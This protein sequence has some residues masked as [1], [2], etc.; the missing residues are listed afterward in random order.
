MKILCIGD[1]HGRNYWKNWVEQHKDADLIIFLGD[2]VDSIFGVSNVEILHN[3]KEIIYFRKTHDNVVTLLGNHDI[4]YL[5]DMARSAYHYCSG[6]RAEAYWDLHILF[7][8]NRHLF[9]AAYKIQNYLFTHAGISN[10][11]FDSY[12]QPDENIDKLLNIEFLRYNRCMFDIGFARLG[13]NPVGGPFWA[14]KT[15]TMVDP[16]TGY[17]QIVGHTRFSE[18]TTVKK[19]DNTS[20]TFVD[21]INEPYIL[22]I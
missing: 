10:Q 20:I 22:N 5:Y 3:L 18:V 2:Y 16:L 13:S 17:H 14:H 4:P 12:F 9:K 7:D 6:F 21:V 15:E 8:E 11:W 19:D 1:V